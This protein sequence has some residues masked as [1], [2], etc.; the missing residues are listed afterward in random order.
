MAFAICCVSEVSPFAYGVHSLK[1]SH[2][3]QGGGCVPIG[4]LL[5]LWRDNLN[6]KLPPF[7]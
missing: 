1:E 2:A 5:L 6:T 4:G 7:A 3:H